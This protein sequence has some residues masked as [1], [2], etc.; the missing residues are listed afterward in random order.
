MATQ[1][2]SSRKCERC[3][4]KDNVQFTGQSHS[5]PHPS[6]CENTKENLPFGKAYLCDDCIGAYYD[7]VVY[8]Q[9][10][11]QDELYQLFLRGMMSEAEFF[12]VQ[13]YS[14]LDQN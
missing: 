11:E 1:H 5:Y 7:Q 12:G 2:Y 13:D 6:D 9:L 10:Q 4:S 14:E 3:G 8:P